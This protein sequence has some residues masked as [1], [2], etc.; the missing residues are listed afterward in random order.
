MLLREHVHQRKLIK[1]IPVTDTNGLS[2]LCNS[3]V[4]KHV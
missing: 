1:K 4:S 3:V 2:C